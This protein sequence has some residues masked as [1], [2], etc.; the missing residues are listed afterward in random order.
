MNTSGRGHLF[1]WGKT[2]GLFFHKSMR[3]AGMAGLA[4]QLPA[5]EWGLLFVRLQNL[6]VGLSFRGA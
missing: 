5:G 1:F 2:L 3:G 6:C 4:F